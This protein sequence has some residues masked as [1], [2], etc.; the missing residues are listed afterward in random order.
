MVKLQNALVG[1]RQLCTQLS[2]FKG[3]LAELLHV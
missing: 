2:I 3:R 1:S